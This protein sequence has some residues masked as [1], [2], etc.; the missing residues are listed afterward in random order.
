M[1][2]S[3]ERYL[4]T[5]RQAA[6]DAERDPRCLAEQGKVP[7]LR[8]QAPR[9]HQQGQ[10]QEHG[11]ERKGWV[12]GAVFAI[13]FSLGSYHLFSTLLRVPLPQGPFRF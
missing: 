10:S 4:P 5:A 8:G 13:G 3:L 1:L 7:G 9:N 12:V 2:T 6:T 11:D